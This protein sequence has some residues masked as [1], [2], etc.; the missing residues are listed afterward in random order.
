MIDVAV[1]KDYEVD[2]LMAFETDL[3]HICH[4]ALFVEEST[5]GER[6]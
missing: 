1:Y 4:K 6:K 2:N 5:T 3:I